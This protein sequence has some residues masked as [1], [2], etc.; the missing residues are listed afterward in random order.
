MKET[1][2]YPVIFA[3]E[4]CRYEQ[5]MARM[6]KIL[7]KGEE[8]FW[9]AESRLT[10]Q[11][12]NRVLWDKKKKWYGV[13]HADRT[14]DTRVGV[15]GLFPFAYRLADKNLAGQARSNF[16]KLIGPYGI[17]TIAPGEPGFYEETYWRGPAWPKSCS[18]ALAAAKYHYPDLAE[19]VKNGLVE[20]ILKYPSVWEC[21]NV[22]TGK[23][24]RGD[25]GLMATP[26][27]SSNVGAGEAMGALLTYYGTDMFSMDK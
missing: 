4:R 18:V 8:A 27:I 14:L 19:R 13:V 6:S 24:A 15:D 12:M 11:A 22:A 5:A 10:L 7:G 21:M 3:A 26:V 25:V 17:Y 1:F 23:I 2:C 16:K 20:F 9:L